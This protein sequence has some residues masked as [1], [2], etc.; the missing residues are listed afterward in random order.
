[1]E[2]DVDYQ[3][4]TF[5]QSCKTFL[6]NEKHIEKLQSA[7]ERMHHIKILATELLHFHIYRC[8]DDGVPLPKINQTW[9]RQLFKE[10]SVLDGNKS[11]SVEKSD[12]VHLTESAQILNAK[13]HDSEK[14][15][16][17]HLTNILSA[18][19]TTLLTTI[20]VNIERHFKTRIH[21]FVRSSFDLHVRLPSDEYK[22]HKLH[23]LQVTEDICRNGSVDMQSPSMFHTWIQEQR[24]CMGLTT[25][26]K[27]MSFL[28]SVQLDF[29]KFLPAMNIMNEMKEQTGKSTFSLLPMTRKMRPGFIQLDIQAWK[30]VLGVSELQSRKEK[31]KMANLKRNEEKANGTYV[32]REEK[33]K[34]KKEEQECTRKRKREEN[35]AQEQQFQQ[36]GETKEKKKTRKEREKKERLEI[37]RINRVKKEMK[38]QEEKDEKDAFYAGF[39]QVPIHKKY[40]FA[41]SVKT[42]GVSVRLFYK[43]QIKKKT[44]ATT[45][46]G[47]PKRGLYTID[48]LKHFSRLS[49]D[50]MEIIG[51]DPGM[52]DLIHAVGDDY[53]NDPTK[54]YSYSAAQRRH[55][56]CSIL[57]AK[58][59]QN[60]KPRDVQKAEQV[61][62]CFNSRSTRKE[63][64]EGYFDARRCHLQDFLDF[65]GLLRY[66]I[67]RW[68]TFKKDQ[69]SIAGL[70]NNLKALKDK[71]LPHKTIVL[72]YGSWVKASSTFNPK[73]IAPC[74]GIGLRRRLSSEFVIVDTPEHFTS[75]TCARCLHECGPF[76]QLEK[77]RREK[78]IC[79]AKTEE[80][81]KKAKR[82]TIRSIRRCQNAECGVILNRDR[83]AAANIALNF[84]RL[85]HGL[86]P[87]KK[88][89]AIDE[90]L[91]KLTCSVALY[92]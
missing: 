28:Q 88:Q 74:I 14:P 71:A 49:E 10:M 59:M 56:R 51:V 81:Q 36:L 9:C 67:R 79:K 65:Y 2:N 70:I 3:E 89:S 87:L 44:K 78:H 60:E 50:D 84:R 35:N 61:M 15:S 31:R 20:K 75:K 54:S 8:L 12:D 38:K 19:A 66:R 30:E 40:F 24:D 27:D 58:K 52:R 86:A 26:L 77:E 7:V 72:A 1:M 92:A 45:K 80:E 73:G 69:R 23:M 34:R 57:Y 90:K 37:E 41:H 4:K 83:N 33:S 25:L 29:V 48:Q 5:V 13:I 21:S 63:I 17:S 82:Y 18:E 16:R 42:D 46:S 53:I 39:A 64:R 32:S 68:R 55:E 76:V 62:S 22:I 43:K 85:Y 47:K 11:P 6:P 91:E